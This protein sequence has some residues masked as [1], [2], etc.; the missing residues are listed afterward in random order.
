MEGL[1]NWASPDYIQD[2]GDG[3]S[4]EGIE[5]LRSQ[6][7]ACSA[8]ELLQAVK[9]R[10]VW[11]RMDRIKRFGVAFESTLGA[12]DEKNPFLGN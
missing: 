11:R 4:E 12:Y 5:R 1:V 2:I 6:S 8:A 10:K 7:D 9:E 3:E